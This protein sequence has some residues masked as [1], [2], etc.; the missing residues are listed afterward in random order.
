MKMAP[1]VKW[2]VLVVGNAY[3]TLKLRIPTKIV[4]ENYTTPLENERYPDQP[5]LENKN[6]PDPWSC[7]YVQRRMG[8]RE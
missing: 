4:I 7:A 1:S 2:P 3:I 5:S 6:A 8:K